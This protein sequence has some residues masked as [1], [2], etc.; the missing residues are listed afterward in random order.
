M[1]DDGVLLTFYGDADGDGYGSPD[2]PVEAGSSQTVCVLTASYDNGVDFGTVSDFT[3]SD[4]NISVDP[5]F[6]DVSSTD[7]TAW[8]LSLDS[9][10]AL[11]DA[12]DP[13][14]LDADGSTRDIGPTSGPEGDSW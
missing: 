13:S 11:I 2:Q 9:G 1:V 7:P 5:G 14:I 3:G 10:S 4:G 6:T 12:S 8:D